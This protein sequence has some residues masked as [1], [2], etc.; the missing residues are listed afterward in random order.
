V[1]V[2]VQLN[3]NRIADLGA[4]LMPGDELRVCSKSPGALSRD[5][6]W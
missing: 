5:G 6:P 3:L 1:E 4:W 2:L